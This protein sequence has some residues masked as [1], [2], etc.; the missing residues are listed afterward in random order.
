MKKIAFLGLIVVIFSKPCFAQSELNQ[1][2]PEEFFSLNNTL[3][4][5]QD[6]DEIIGFYHGIVYAC[7]NPII[8]TPV[9]D[10]FYL[11]IIFISYFQMAIPEYSIY[12]L[13]SPLFGSGQAIVNDEINNEKEKYA[14]RKIQDSWTPD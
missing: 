3:W 4:Q 6:R 7:I 12:G 9:D 14:I 11:D 10:S 8:C 2:Q 1:I 13:L 5:L